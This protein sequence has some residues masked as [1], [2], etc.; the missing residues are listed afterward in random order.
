MFRH[1]RMGVPEGGAGGPDRARRDGFRRGRAVPRGAVW[2]CGAVVPAPAPDRHLG[3]LG[4]TEGPAVRRL[5]ARLAVATCLTLAA[6]PAAF[7]KSRMLV[8]AIPGLRRRWR[9]T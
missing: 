4:R 3:L 6:F 5:V 7:R 8:C 9:L 2:P 1:A